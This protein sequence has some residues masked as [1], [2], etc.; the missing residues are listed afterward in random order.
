ML[1]TKCPQKES[2][3]NLSESSPSKEEEFVALFAA[4][5]R[6]LHAYVLAMVFDANSAADILQETNIVLW[7]KFEQY[8]PGTNFL[9]WAREIARIAVLRYRQ[10]TSRRLVP[11][12]PTQLEELAIG[13]SEATD[14]AAS[15][16]KSALEQCLKKLRPKDHKLILDRYSSGVPVMRIAEQI[17]RTANSVTQ[18]LCRIRRLLI[19]CTQREL[20]KSPHG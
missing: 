7:Q 1:Q 15:D 5:Q 12:D 18:S 4:N 17:G 14:A 20:N 8:E 16:K 3:V 2:P 19:D 11:V 9:A 10:K 6:R 13:F